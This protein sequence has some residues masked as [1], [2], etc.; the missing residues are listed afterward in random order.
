MGHI[1]VIHGSYMGHGSLNEY[2]YVGHADQPWVNH[3]SYL[4][5]AWILWVTWVTGVIWNGSW[6]K[7]PL[8]IAGRYRLGLP[9]GLEDGEWY[10]RYRPQTSTDQYTGKADYLP[11]CINSIKMT[12]NKNLNFTTIKIVQLIKS[13]DRKWMTS[14]NKIDWKWDFS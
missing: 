5:Q 2:Y 12:N 4:G 6:P 9:M 14:N 3:G 1:W 13:S 8:V 11:W 10:Q 7:R